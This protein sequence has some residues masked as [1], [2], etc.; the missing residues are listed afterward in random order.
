VRLLA[1]LSRQHLAL[2]VAAL[3]LTWLSLVLRKQVIGEIIAGIVLGPSVLGRIPG[4]LL[5]MSIHKSIN[6][7][8]V[9]SARGANHRGANHRKGPLSN[10]Q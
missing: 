10:H 5:K 8:H 7:L 9:F 4:E 1:P 2:P 3:L 6:E